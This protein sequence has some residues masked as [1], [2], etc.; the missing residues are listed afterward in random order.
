[1]RIS[2][3]KGPCRQSVIDLGAT[4]IDAATLCRAIRDPD[5]DRVQCATPGALHGRVGHISPRSAPAIRPSLAL[6]MR[7]QRTSTPVDR[8]LAAAQSERAQLEVPMVDLD[9]VRQAVA[10]TRQDKRALRERVARL[11]GKV[12]ALRETD[13]GDPTETVEAL[14]SAAKSLSEAE[15]GHLAAVQRLE[16]KREAAR[17]ARN[18]ENRR[19]QLTDRIGNLRQ[20]ARAYLVETGWPCFTDAVDTLPIETVVGSDPSSWSGPGWVAAIALLQMAD[21]EAPV[22][23]EGAQQRALATPD[24]LGTTVIRI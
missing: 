13:G 7:S 14:Q 10:E 24:R 5:D 18:V 16:E 20:D 22:V 2:I 8:S 21:V 23:V 12:S 3:G 1:M 15:T 19:L 6:A 9:A 17:D 4:D 11:G